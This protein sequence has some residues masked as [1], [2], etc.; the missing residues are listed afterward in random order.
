MR[1]SLTSNFFGQQY[2]LTVLYL[3]WNGDEWLEYNN[4][5]L[6]DGSECKWFGVICDTEGTVVGIEQTKK[7]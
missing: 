3:E 1:Y 4:T 5:C 7:D 6:D 2:V